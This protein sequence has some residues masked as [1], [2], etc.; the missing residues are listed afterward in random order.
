MHGYVKQYAHL[1]P[2]LSG[3]SCT[4]ITLTYLMNVSRLYLSKLQSNFS[5]KSEQHGKRTNLGVFF[6][7]PLATNQITESHRGI[8]ILSKII[9]VGTLQ[10]N[11]KG[12]V[13]DCPVLFS[14]VR[15]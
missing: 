10:E 14:L 5:V 4:N 11:L 9:S 12:E 3:R 13:T 15:L 7:I 2:H 6:F 8:F 1:K